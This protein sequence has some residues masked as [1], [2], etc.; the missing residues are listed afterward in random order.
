MKI[1]AGAKTHRGLIRRINEDFYLAVE[2]MHKDAADPDSSECLF[3]VADGMSGHGGGAV[4]SRTACHVLAVQYGLR[5]EGNAYGNQGGAVIDF[6]EEA[7][8]KAHRKILSGATK[9]SG[10]EQM[11]TTLSALVLREDMALIAHVGDSRI[12]RL[13]GGRLEQ[14][15]EDH[16]MANLSVEM[17][18]LSREEA[19]THPQRHVLLQ[20]LGQGVDEVQTLL[21]KTM[22]GDIFLLCS[23]GLYHMVPDVTIQAI[24]S[25][26]HGPEETCDGLIRMALKEGGKDNITAMVIQVLGI[27]KT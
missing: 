15:T 12:Y 16:T 21:E 1:R 27:G 3:A 11:G 23:D 4:A 8:W 17:G 5:S 2:H 26:A 22:H 24:L 13:R 25:S 10:G 18:Y 6:L 20:A 9:V 7:L 19:K 14:F